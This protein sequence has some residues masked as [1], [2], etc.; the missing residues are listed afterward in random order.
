MKQAAA[1]CLLFAGM[2]TEYAVA[3]PAMLLSRNAIT[4][5]ELT[6]ESEVR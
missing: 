6:L 5:T 1:L 4:R 2:L 3:Q